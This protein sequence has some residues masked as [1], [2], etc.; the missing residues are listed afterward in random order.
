MDKIVYDV[1]IAKEVDSVPGKLL[2]YWYFIV[3]TPSDLWALYSHEKE[4]GEKAWDA[5]LFGFIQRQ[6]NG[7]WDCFAMQWCG[8][9]PNKFY[10]M[11][12]VYN[13]SV[14]QILRSA[15]QFEC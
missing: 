13:H 7:S 2:L 14:E 10:A 3:G 15:A 12:R 9:E 6:R 8:N 4:Y 11:E 1:E 5:G